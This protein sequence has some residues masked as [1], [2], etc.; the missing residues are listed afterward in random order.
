MNRA[1]RARFDAILE[2]EIAALPPGIGRFLEEM[3]V[4]VEDLP[5]AAVLR[6]LGMREEEA[7]E[8]CGLHSGTANTE[9]SVEGM[10]ELPSEIQ[11]Y[12][13]GIVAEAGGWEGP[14]APE[15]VREQIR[16]TLLH[17]IGH[18]LGLDEDDLEALGYQ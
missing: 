11:L 7:E 10:G 16:I 3:P 12:R 15:R 5:S 8:L 14:D 1:E 2:S 6:E 17:E 13:V 4:V 9:R 18:Q